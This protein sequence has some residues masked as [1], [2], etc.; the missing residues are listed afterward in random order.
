MFSEGYSRRRI[1]LSRL[2]AVTS[3]SAAKRY[4]LWRRKGSIDVGKDADLVFIDPKSEWVV[5]GDRFLSKGHIT[6]FEGFKFKGRIVRT[7]L[8]GSTVYDYQRGIIG[9]PGRGIHLKRGTAAG[10]P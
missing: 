3:S 7:V 10:T 1:S 5:R 6:P 9:A 2:T 8:R 4:G